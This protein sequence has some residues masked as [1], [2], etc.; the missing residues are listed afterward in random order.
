M[1]ATT[2]DPLEITKQMEKE[3]LS[4]IDWNTKEISQIML[5]MEKES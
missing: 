5:S 1:E 3:N 2:K 4:K